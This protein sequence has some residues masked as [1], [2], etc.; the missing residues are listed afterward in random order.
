MFLDDH[1]EDGEHGQATVLELPKLRLRPRLFRG[2]PEP[3]GVEAEVAP[4]T[5]LLPL[6]VTVHFYGEDREENLEE[7]ERTLF[8][9]LVMS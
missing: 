4:N 3:E 2:R 1:S 5:A 8:V 7:R 6:L 9:Y